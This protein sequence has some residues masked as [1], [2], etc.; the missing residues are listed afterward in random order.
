MLLKVTNFFYPRLLKF[1][2]AFNA[3]QSHVEH[4]GDFGGERVENSTNQSMLGTEANEQSENCC[5]NGICS[6]E[7][8]QDGEANSHAKVAQNKIMRKVIPYLCP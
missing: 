7:I 1:L 3:E 5:I 2:M 4:A 8:L 6:Q